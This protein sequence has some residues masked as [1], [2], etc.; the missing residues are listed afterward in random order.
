MYDYTRM[1]VS[2]NGTRVGGNFHTMGLMSDY[3]LSKRTDVYAQAVYQL[4]S[5]STRGL[6]G[7]VDAGGYSSGKSQVVAR[8]GLRHKF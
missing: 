8:V 1:T 6:V 2:G 4:G 5:E 7:V 3:S